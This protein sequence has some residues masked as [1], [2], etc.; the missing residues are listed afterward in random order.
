MAV[1]TRPVDLTGI[2]ATWLGLLSRAM[3]R[4]LAAR[5]AVPAR[6]VGGRPV[7]LAR[8]RPR[9]RRPE[10]LRG[11]RR[12]LDRVPTRPG[13]PRPSPAPRAA[14]T[15]TYDLARY[16]LTRAEVESAFADYN[17]LRAEVDRA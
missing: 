9:D 6:A 14:R 7:L 2:G 13:S 10:A 4:G 8:L 3:T 1:S 11:R 15:H 12:P 16:G 17:A 5:A